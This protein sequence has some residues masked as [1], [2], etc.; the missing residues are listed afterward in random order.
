MK[1]F[2]KKANIL[3]FVLV[4]G[5]LISFYLGEFL[6]FTFAQKIFVGI[7]FLL[8]VLI[9]ALTPRKKSQRELIEENDERNQYILLKCMAETLKVV[10][11]ACFLTIISNLIC[12]GLTREFF[13]IWVLIG[14]TIPYGVLKISMIIFSFRYDR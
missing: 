5:V 1:Y 11:Y 4:I 12:F 6:S 8:G 2:R 13:F 9:I 3:D 7:V 14:T 10:G